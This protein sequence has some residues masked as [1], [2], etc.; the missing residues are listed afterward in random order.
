LRQRLLDFQ[1][2]TGMA[3]TTALAD[4]SYFSDDGI[5]WADLQTVDAS[6][7]FAINGLTIIT[8]PEPSSILLCAAGGLLAWWPRRSRRCR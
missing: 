8:V 4:E 6:A 3:Q 7:N 5:T 1:N 2:A